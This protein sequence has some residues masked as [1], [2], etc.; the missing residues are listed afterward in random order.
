MS[1]CDITTLVDEVIGKRNAYVMTDFFRHSVNGQLF[2]AVRDN[3]FE[4]FYIFYSEDDGY[5]HIH[6]GNAEDFST[7]ISDC[8]ETNYNVASDHGFHKSRFAPHHN[9]ALMRGLEVINAQ[10]AAELA[11]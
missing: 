4:R 5:E 11:A 9:K 2:A 6:I 7:F 1:F 10:K 3:A 8:Y